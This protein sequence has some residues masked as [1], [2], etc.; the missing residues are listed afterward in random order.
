MCGNP[1]KDSGC[2]AEGVDFPYTVRILAM[3]TKTM[4]PETQQTL[5]TNWQGR[6]YVA[7]QNPRGIECAITA[8]RSGLLR[9]ALEYAE[10]FEGCK[11]GDDGVIGDAWLEM[12]R[13]YLGLLNSE[14]GRLDCGSLDHEVREWAERFGFDEKEIDSL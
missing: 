7:L 2:T 9:Y 6:H 11:L 4:G 12:A 1:S 10:R 14:T 3:E 13:G 5:S 8:L